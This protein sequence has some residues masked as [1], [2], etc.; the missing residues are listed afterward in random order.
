M[1]YLPA[2]FGWKSYGKFE[3]SGNGGKGGGWVSV[4]QEVPVR[5]GHRYY[6][7]LF[8]RAAG[9]RPELQQPGPNRGYAF[10]E[11]S[12]TWLTGQNRYIAGVGINRYLSYPINNAAVWHKL[13]PQSASWHVQSWY[14]APPGAAEAVI[15]LQIGVT[16]ARVT[17][18]VYVD[19]VEFTQV[20]ARHSKAGG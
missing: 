5:A 3:N 8:Y 10:F 11:P 6:V 13:T 15:A 4:Q 19:D 1:A 16:R 18:Q 7:R 2:A 20:G 14:V 9:L 12:V 17:P